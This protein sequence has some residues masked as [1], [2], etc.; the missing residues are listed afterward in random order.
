MS[1]HRTMQS[2]VLL[3][4]SNTFRR[5]AAVILFSRRTAEAGRECDE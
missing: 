2:R 4:M 3:Q 5:L 1:E